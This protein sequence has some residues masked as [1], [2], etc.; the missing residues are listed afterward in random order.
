MIKQSQRPEP[1]PEGAPIVDEITYSGTATEA[2]DE[3][4]MTD[5]VTVGVAGLSAFVSQFEALA[6]RPA[7]SSF[8]LKVANSDMK[9]R[10]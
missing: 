10:S 1:I 8:A 2:Q 5:P 4:G 9:R 3:S 6:V 7:R